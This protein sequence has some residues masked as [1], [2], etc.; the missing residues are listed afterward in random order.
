[1]R[2]ALLGNCELAVDITPPV[3]A[4]LAKLANT[5]AHT[6]GPVN[7]APLESSTR[8]VVTRNAKAV[9]RGGMERAKTHAAGAKPADSAT[10]LVWLM[11]SAVGSALLVGMATKEQLQVF[12]LVNAQ[13]VPT[14]KLVRQNVLSVVLEDT[15]CLDRVN[16]MPALQ[17]G[18]VVMN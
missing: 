15:A 3:S 9:W 11:L 14:V 16:A 6:L 8:I 7:G 4:P 5:T 13:L 10:S 2:H 1:V 17:A 18:M 12:V